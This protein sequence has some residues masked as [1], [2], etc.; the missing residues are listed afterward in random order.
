MA[1]PDLCQ[2]RAQAGGLY[3]S[4]RV[5]KKRLAYLLSHRSMQSAHCFWVSRRGLKPTRSVVHVAVTAG[6]AASRPAST[7]PTLS[8]VMIARASFAGWRRSDKGEINR[9]LLLE[10]LLVVGTLD[11]GL[12]FVER[13][14]LDQDI[15]LE[16]H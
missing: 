11:G 13:R 2:S 5:P 16:T 8:P 4:P 15:A 9:D 14:V 10:Q 1:K 7:T 6:T 3:S 12:R